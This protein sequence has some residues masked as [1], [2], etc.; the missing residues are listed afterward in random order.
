VLDPANVFNMDVLFSGFTPTSTVTCTSG[1]GT[2]KLYSIQMATGYAAID[3]A[4]G[5]A[6]STTDASVTRSTTIGQGIASMP[7]VVA[8]IADAVAMP[9]PAGGVTMTTASRRCP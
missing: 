3:F 4:T 2:A 6:L 8:V 5:T 9:E 1:G 7:V